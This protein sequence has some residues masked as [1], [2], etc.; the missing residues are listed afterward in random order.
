MHVSPS[1]TLRNNPIEVS[2][3]VVQYMRENTEAT[4]ENIIHDLHTLGIKS[5]QYVSALAS[6]GRWPEDIQDYCRQKRYAFSKLRELVA[7]KDFDT[8]RE[9]LGMDK[10]NVIPHPTAS[11]IAELE[12]AVSAFQRGL[13]SLDS[14][15]SQMQDDLGSIKESI[16]SIK[17]ELQ[18][19][20][21]LAATNLDVPALREEIRT[22]M[23]AAFQTIRQEQLEHLKSV[24]EMVREIRI[25]KLD[26]RTVIQANPTCY[27]TDTKKVTPKKSAID[28][29]TAWLKEISPGV[30]LFQLGMVAA[31]GLLIHNNIQFFGTD[32]I[33]MT[34]ALL[35]ESVL[36]ASGLLLPHCRTK[37]AMLICVA[38]IGG[39]IYVNGQVVANG[40]DAK[41]AKA[42]SEY[43]RELN[44][45]ADAAAESDN[46]LTKIK[47]EIV[48]VE[49]Q[50]RNLRS[51]QQ[52]AYA[53]GR[54]TAGRRMNEEI[55]KA[56]DD[57]KAM[58][59][60]MESRYAEIKSGVQSSIPAIVSS[61]TNGNFFIQFTC[62]ALVILGPLML[63]GVQPRIL[64][65]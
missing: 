30:L 37:L 23:A 57:M 49:E 44:S 1:L 47:T 21:K 50:I 40:L 28:D 42:A 41:K 18:A 48:F 64:K 17:T 33:G 61:Q 2:I 62:L 38:G 14:E 34:Q 25:N 55:T 11:K 58:R 9:K 60:E 15:Q 12:T 19:F 56:I 31:Y 32:L 29:I 27:E 52:A 51:Q 13:K 4:R 45:K 65:A 7:E 8:L 36:F 16:E 26:D 63:S 53:D 39:L 22:E 35:V 24:S 46:V 3:K 5:A 59:K 6:I 10:S 20:R 43:E 54:I